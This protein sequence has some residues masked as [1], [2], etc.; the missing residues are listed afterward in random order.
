M[1]GLGKDWPGWLQRGNVDFDINAIGKACFSQQLLCAG[2]VLWTFDIGPILIVRFDRRITGH[3]CSAAHD[4]LD[5][6]FAVSRHANRL[7]HTHIGKWLDI[8]AE[9]K[10]TPVSCRHFHHLEFVAA[11]EHWL[12]LVGDSVLKIDLSAEQSLHS[13]LTVANADDFHLRNTRR[14]FPVIHIGFKLRHTSGIK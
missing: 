14:T 8:C 10:T 1:I 4:Q 3:C 5:Q 7:T 11:S 9:D 13:R 12:L 6:F 2:N